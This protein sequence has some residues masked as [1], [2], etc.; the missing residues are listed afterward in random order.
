VDALLSVVP[1]HRLQRLFD[2]LVGPLP[3]DALLRWF[4]PIEGENPVGS[5]QKHFQSLNFAEL[6]QTRVDRN[7]LDDQDSTARK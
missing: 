7:A 5:E 1:A 6:F 2:L 4:N 3:V